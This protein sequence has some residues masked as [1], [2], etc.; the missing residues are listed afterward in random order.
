MRE[1]LLKGL[2]GCDGSFVRIW[3]DS[4]DGLSLQGSS[5]RKL[6]KKH[7]RDCLSSSLY[8]TVKDEVS[9]LLLRLNK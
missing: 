6:R 4:V 7:F 9:P 1:A 5:P 8:E 2:W 3:N